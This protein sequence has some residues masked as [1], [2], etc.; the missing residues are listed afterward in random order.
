VPVHA[1]A[2]L[3]EAE[4]PGHSPA[5]YGADP[6]STYE[7]LALA[8][9]GPRAA[10]PTDAATGAGRLVTSEDAIRRF[11][12]KVIPLAVFCAVV[13]SLTAPSALLL[14][15]LIE[16]EALPGDTRTLALVFLFAS[17]AGSLVGLMVYT[18]PMALIRRQER[19]V[20]RSVH[21]ELEAGAELK[22]LNKVLSQKVHAAVA[23]MRVLSD[24][25]LDMQENERLRIARDLHDGVGQSLAAL[26]LELDHAARAPAGIR[27]GVGEAQRI[28][29]EALLG[30]RQAVYDLRPPEIG[31][32]PL[33]EIFQSYC[34]RF[35]LRSG[36]ATSL[37]WRGGTVEAPAAAT[38]LLRILQEAFTNI[39]KHAEANEVGVSVHVAADYVRLTIQ[40]D[41][42]GFEAQS[43][44]SG[45]GLRGIQERCAFFG[46]TCHV[47]ADV[48]TGTRLDVSLP[49]VSAQTGETRA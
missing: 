37:R 5:Q 15:D 11:R 26:R 34:E 14:T 49:L 18:V 3:K 10:N 8:A 16:G 41:G 28:L 12:R 2:R 9:Y 42:R 44:H 20:E 24:S 7:D 17:F 43:P 39:A 4:A 23:H 46:G 40:D 27:N 33:P 32:T 36:L 21:R 30:L 22:A 25:M 35:E 38:C 19:L 45:T 1:G 29:D 13:V 31:V 6:P 48:G 47:A